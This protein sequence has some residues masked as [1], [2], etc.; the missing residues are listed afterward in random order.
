MTK[1][2][3]I[4][5]RR[6]RHTIHERHFLIEV[7]ES[8]NRKDTE[9][10]IGKEVI[11]KSPAGKIIKGKISAAHGNKGVLRA[12]FEKGLPG[13]AITTGVEIK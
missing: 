8:K 7:D 11:W 9:K 6:G 4:Q 13:Q 2:K 5:F 3:V 10:F 1:A 12:I